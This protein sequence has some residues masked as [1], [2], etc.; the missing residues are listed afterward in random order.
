MGIDAWVL[1]LR[2]VSEMHRV[3]GVSFNCG[4]LVDLTGSRR[5]PLTTRFKLEQR[6]YTAI[7]PYLLRS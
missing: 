2:V 6:Y 4:E 7:R 1:L 3:G 5:F